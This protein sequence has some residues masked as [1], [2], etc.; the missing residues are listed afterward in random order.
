LPRVG[1]V[2]LC[3][4]VEAA[5][6]ADLVKLHI[7]LVNDSTSCKTSL[8]VTCAVCPH[9]NEDM[10]LTTAFVNR[11]RCVTGINSVC[12]TQSDGVCGNSNSSDS[13]DSVTDTS[14]SSTGFGVIKTEESDTD[15]V[16][17]VGNKTSITTHA[18]LKEQQ[19]D[20]THLSLVGIKQSKVKM[21]LRYVMGCYMMLKMWP[22]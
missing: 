19:C 9:L 17:L 10:I 14:V 12:A 4:V 3:G 15:C 2:R 7:S 21:D 20:E 13:V 1:T 5:V 22:A 11:L 6:M 8:P 16:D 18:F